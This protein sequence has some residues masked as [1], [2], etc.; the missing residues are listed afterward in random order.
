[1]GSRSI[2]SSQHAREPSGRDLLHP[3]ERYGPLSPSAV[4]W[5][6]SLFGLWTAFY[7]AAVSYGIWLT[8]EHAT[9]PFAGFLAVALTFPT[10]LLALV[11]PPGRAWAGAMIAVSALLNVWFVYVMVKRS[12]R[13]EPPP[14]A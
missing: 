14:E 3:S 1:M 4:R 7:L 6:Y 13:R 9:D 10:S 12:M 5:R 11:A 2:M 8:F